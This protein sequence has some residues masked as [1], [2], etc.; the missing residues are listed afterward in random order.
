[1]SYR[2]IQTA[3]EMVKPLVEKHVYLASWMSELYFMLASE[4][5]KQNKGSDFQAALKDMVSLN[6]T[7]PKVLLRFKEDVPSAIASQINDSAVALQNNLREFTRNWYEKSYVFFSTQNPSDYPLAI[8]YLQW[9]VE[10]EIKM[11]LA[12]YEAPSFETPAGV[13][14]A[15]ALTPRVLQGIETIWI[16]PS[17]YYLG[18]EDKARKVIKDNGRIVWESSSNLSEQT[19][20][21]YLPIIL[22]HSQG[23]RNIQGFWGESSIFLVHGSREAIAR[24]KYAFREKYKISK[25][26]VIK[27]FDGEHVLWNSS[28]MNHLHS[29]DSGAETLLHLLLQYP[30]YC[31]INRWS[32]P[33]PNL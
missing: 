4:T 21:G 31:L 15:F 18:I 24:A 1:I 28:T 12:N 32:Y 33:H 14:P 27:W 17:A 25:G 5:Y 22:S 16:K 23:K 30:E 2:D 7:R 13:L 11:G 8:R 9:A 29:T 20:H 10:G 26:T 3:I 19:K 6:P